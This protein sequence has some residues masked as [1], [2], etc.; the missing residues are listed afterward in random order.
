MD[1]GVPSDQS[2][3]GRTSTGANAATNARSISDSGGANSDRMVPKE[4][5][6]FQ[7][8]SP[9][10]IVKKVGFANTVD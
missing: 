1:L 10:T 8:C 5:L 9:T 3:E 4:L 6:D 2:I 7:L